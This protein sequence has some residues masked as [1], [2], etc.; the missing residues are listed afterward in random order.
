MS[1]QEF[2]GRGFQLVSNKK[3]SSVYECF[4]FSSH[5]LI[6]L[7]LVTEQACSKNFWMPKQIGLPASPFLKGRLVFDSLLSH[8][9][10]CSQ[11]VL[12]SPA[13]GV[14]VFINPSQWNNG[15][16]I[17]LTSDWHGTSHG[18]QFRRM[19]QEGKTGKRA[20]LFVKAFFP[21]KR[22]TE[23]ETL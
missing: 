1:G 5:F 4:Y 3:L 8:K 13:S 10:L 2:W 15:N 9:T 6:P 19:G 11:K 7:S 17:S 16:C 14:W 18:T 21:L 23:K 12:E 20:Q 22:N